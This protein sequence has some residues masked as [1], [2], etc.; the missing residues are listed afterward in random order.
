MGNNK[1]EHQWGIHSV[2]LWYIL[3]MLDE[4]AAIGGKKK[5]IFM[6][7]FGK[8]SRMSQQRKQGSEG[9]REI[10]NKNPFVSENVSSFPDSSTDGTTVI[11]KNKHKK[12]LAV[13]GLGWDFGFFSHFA[14]MECSTGLKCV[15]L[16]CSLLCAQQS[17]V[18]IAVHGVTGLLC[19]SHQRWSLIA[20]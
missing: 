19:F 9:Q 6:F 13:V 5:Y 8:K 17:E 12:S 10:A 3:K 16:S 1:G 18:P 4:S 20:L 7:R 2:K 11:S 14:Q 15:C